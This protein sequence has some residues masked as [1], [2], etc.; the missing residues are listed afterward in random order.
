MKVGECYGIGFSGLWF[1][2]SRYLIIW[3]D[4]IAVIVAVVVAVVYIT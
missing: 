4:D 1:N 3:E 2:E